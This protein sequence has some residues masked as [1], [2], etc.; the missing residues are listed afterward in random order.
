MNKA[1]R[2][3]IVMLCLLLALAGCGRPAKPTVIWQTDINDNLSSPVVVG[4]LAYI[5]SSKGHLFALALTKKTLRW[6]FEAGDELAAPAVVDGVVYVGSQDHHLYAL[7]AATGKELWRFDA[8]SE[9]VTV[10]TIDADTVYIGSADGR[11]Y[12]IE[13]ASGAERWRMQLSG[14][15][16]EGRIGD[17]QAY[18]I[19]GNGL[20][21]VSTE[22]DPSA[23]LYAIDPQSQRI[24]WSIDSDLFFLSAPAVDENSVYVGSFGS[25]WAFD[26]Q[27]GA[28]RWRQ[29]TDAGFGTPLLAGDRLYVGASTI[30]AA[31]KK[32]ADDGAGLY[33]L[34]TPTGDILW[35]QPTKSPIFVRP[36][37]LGERVYALS[38]QDAYSVEAASGKLVRTLEFITPN[39][40]EPG[41][42]NGRVLVGGD[43]GRLY[44]FEP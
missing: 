39:G 30:S 8:Q 5:S 21:Y 23:H 44:Q 32:M 19:V 42:D 41:L 43:F 14:R 11:L 16:S 31:G 36:L 28:L 1:L 35:K 17:A 22:D 18:A 4:D 12:A 38:L 13:R 26:A 25:M 29:A 37:L 6:Q 27:T 10:P 40:P 3:V 15:I 24:V 2:S 9:L 33:A 20:L 34:D 7:D